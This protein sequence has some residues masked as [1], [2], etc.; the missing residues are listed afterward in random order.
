MNEKN[1]SL[2]WVAVASILSLGLFLF[3]FFLYQD[4]KMMP[5]SAVLKNAKKSFKK[6]GP[7]EGSWIQMTPST[8]KVDTEESPV[9]YGGIT[10]KEDQDLKQ[11]E[12]IA[13]A[14]TGQIITTY[15]IAS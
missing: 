3:L 8:Y 10:R 12:F 11:Y 9:Y 5:S 4:R 2:F 14:Y 13:D 15:P 7:I 1:Q 6:D